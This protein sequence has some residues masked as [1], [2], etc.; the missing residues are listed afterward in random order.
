MRTHYYG[1]WDKS[2][3]Q[4]QVSGAYKCTHSWCV[5]SPKLCQRGREGRPTSFNTMYTRL[6]T[7]KHLGLLP[8]LNDRGKIFWPPLSRWLE[9]HQSSFYSFLA[10]GLQILI[11]L[12]RYGTKSN[13]MLEEF[14][15]LTIWGGKCASLGETL[16]HEL[17]HELVTCCGE[18]ESH[19]CFRIQSRAL[20]LS[21]PSLERHTQRVVSMVILNPVKWTTTTNHHR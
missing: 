21:S 3:G 13:L 19:E 16:E 14:I 18:A 1:W 7:L 6:W 10:S 2:H 20:L 5:G 8:F 4:T 17:T 9:C 11:A 15:Y 12:T